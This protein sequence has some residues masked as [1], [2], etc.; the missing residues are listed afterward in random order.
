VSDEEIEIMFP[1]C[2]VW[3]MGNCVM[4]ECENSDDAIIALTVFQRMAEAQD[5]TEATIFRV[6]P[7][8]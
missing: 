5:K 3:P 4:L 8:K 7:S 1:S 2:K 6:L